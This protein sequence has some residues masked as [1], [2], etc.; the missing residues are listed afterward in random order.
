MKQGDLV[1]ASLD[2][3]EKALAFALQFDG[4]K[5]FR[6]SGEMMAKITAAHLVQCLTRGGFVV[7]RRPP[8]PGH[9]APNYRTH[10][11]DES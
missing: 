9:A 3:I 7:L 8:Q 11:A 4:R 1:P 2:E 5:Q 10:L 6:L